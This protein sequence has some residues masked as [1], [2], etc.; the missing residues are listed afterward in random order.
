MMEE[1][2]NDFERSLIGKPRTLGRMSESISPALAEDAR[3]I[4]D[5]SHSRRWFGG[6]GKTS[7]GVQSD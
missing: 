6:D 5:S 7:M 2:G 4:T 1:I 3:L